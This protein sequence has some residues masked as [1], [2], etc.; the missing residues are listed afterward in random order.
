VFDVFL[1]MEDHLCWQCYYVGWKYKYHKEKH[2]S[3]DRG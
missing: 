2:R 1:K 3:S